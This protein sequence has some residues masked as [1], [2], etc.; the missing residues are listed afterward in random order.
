M[1]SLA[2]DQSK[3][4]QLTY[5]GEINKNVKAAIRQASLFSKL[6]GELSPEEQDVFASVAAVGEHRYA[7]E[8]KVKARSPKEIL[9]LA[10]SFAEEMEFA[11]DGLLI[12]RGVRKRGQG[13]S[14]S[15]KSLCRELVRVWSLAMSTPLNSRH[16]SIT[17]IDFY[18]HVL[19]GVDLSIE[20]R[21]VRFRAYGPPGPINRTT[22]ALINFKAHRDEIVSH[23][24][25]VLKEM[26]AEAEATSKEKSEE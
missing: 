25:S 19:G 12:L 3:L 18:K 26:R 10:H 8:V 5:T 22:K 14:K 9:T 20:V 2:N 21:R 13:P 15:T 7:N 6:L 11:K 4:R 1:K 24:T 17:L 16:A 23:L